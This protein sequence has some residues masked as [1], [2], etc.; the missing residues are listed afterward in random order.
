MPGAAFFW[1]YLGC[2]FFFTNLCLMEFL[3]RFSAFFFSFLQMHTL[4]LVILD[5]KSLQDCPINTWV[6]EGTIHGPAR[7]MMILLVIFVI[8]IPMLMV[9]LFTLK[10]IGV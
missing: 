2:W 10:K 8:L 9:L 7:S 4:L 6:P 5:G 1:L 3:A